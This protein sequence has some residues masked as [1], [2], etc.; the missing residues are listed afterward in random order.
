MIPRTPIRERAES[1]AKQAAACGVTMADLIQSDGDAARLE[2]L[3][4]AAIGRTKRAA[5]RDLA[6]TDATAA[7][8]MFCDDFDGSDRKRYLAELEADELVA[9][10]RQVPKHVVTE[11]LNAH[12]HPRI[13][14]A[15]L[16]PDDDVPRYVTLRAPR[17]A[18]TPSR[19]VDARTARALRDAGIEVSTPARNEL[20]AG[21]TAK[22]EP[23]VYR[24]LLLHSAWPATMPV[25][26]WHVL[27]KFDV[28]VGRLVESG[29][30]LVENV[31]LERCRVMLQ[32]QLA[33]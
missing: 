20:P 11:V 9:W 1:L 8:K 12:P 13:V 18:S 24:G 33:T 32:A 14:R 5:F 29:D 10:L 16:T 25:H 31:P 15:E 2:R 26:R 23:Y 28:E 4:A 17:G 21:P 22:L 3:I 6:L 27:E 19:G 7:A 30:I